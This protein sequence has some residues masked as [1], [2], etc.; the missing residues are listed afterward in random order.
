MVSHW[1]QLKTNIPLPVLRKKYIADTSCCEEH[2]YR[3]AARWHLVKQAFN[4][5][6]IYPSLSLGISIFPVFHCTS[7]TFSR[8][9]SLPALLSGPQLFYQEPLRHSVLEPRHLA[10]VRCL[11]HLN[12]SPFFRVSGLPD[13]IKD[14]KRERAYLG[15]YV[16]Q[17]K[18]RQAYPVLSTVTAICQISWQ[19]K[20]RIL[21]C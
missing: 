9:R 8:S 18:C 3:S 1:S 15:H 12:L 11:F 7:F 5:T 21:E 6:T 14:R 19:E 13:I 17:H 2:S 10:G 4:E 20:K 16:E